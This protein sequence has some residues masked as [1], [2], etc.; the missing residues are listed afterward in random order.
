MD[1]RL[2]VLGLTEQNGKVVV[3]SRD[4]ARV[5]G[6]RHDNVLKDVRELK[7][8]EEFG[9][10][11]FEESSYTNEQNKQQ[12]EYLVTRD[13]F[14][15]LAMGYTG[16]TAMRFKEA[17]IK[18]FNEMERKLQTPMLPTTYIHALEALLEAEREKSRLALESNELKIQLDESKEYFTVKRVASLNGL[19]WRSI[20]WR[21][22]V[23]T[24][25]AMECEIKKVFDANYG[26]VNAY[27]ISVWQHE[28]SHLRYAL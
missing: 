14:T 9:L 3:S 24:S 7:V 15:I 17:Y 25:G 21:R 22:L 19:D 23:A 1:K 4:I 10:L 12:P 13:G 8:S 5:F 26:T 16:E 11:N 27:H 6:K 20:S 2:M 28:Y 18:A